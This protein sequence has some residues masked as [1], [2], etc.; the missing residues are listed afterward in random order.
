MERNAKQHAGG[1][2]PAD[3]D[4][5]VGSTPEVHRPPALVGEPPGFRREFLHPRYWHVWLLI[6]V[7]LVLYLFPRRLRDKLG[8]GIGYLNHRFNT[9]RAHYA[10]VNLS[11]CFPRLSEAEREHLSL[12]HFKAQARAMMDLPLFRFAGIRTLERLIVVSG[13]E[14]IYEAQRQGRSVILLCCHTSAMESGGLALSTRMRVVTV[15]N[16]FKSAFADW[17]IFSARTRFDMQL[18]R[19]DDGLRPLIRAVREGAIMIHIPD[20]DL[21][22]GRSVF[23]EFFGRQKATVPVLG[24][25][26]KSC[27]AL[28]VPCYPWYD[29]RVRRY[30]LD[31]LPALD[32]SWGRDVASD[33]ASMNRALQRMIEICPE[34]YMWT[35]RM[36][37]TR[38]NGEPYPYKRR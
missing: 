38:P 28:V 23:A 7:L 6:G 35:M 26:A 24:R 14:H 27:N 21:G 11:W 36:F 5:P 31:L 30:R 2:Q 10:S 8:A 25:L 12:S 16:P 1:Q 18:T 13:I 19:R 15:F 17:W 9:K 29:R 37:K 22:A 34:Q 20:E 33:A 3:S 32:D 4:R